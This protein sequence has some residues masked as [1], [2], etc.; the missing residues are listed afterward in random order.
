MKIATPFAAAH[1][2]TFAQ[3][4]HET[5][6]AYDR[7]LFCSDRMRIIVC[8][9]DRQWV[10]QTRKDFSSAKERPWVARDYCRTKAGI[11]RVT[12]TD[13]ALGIPGLQAFVDG[14]TDRL[15]PITRAPLPPAPPRPALN[16]S[17]GTAT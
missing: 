16:I 4:A 3:A 9:A 7:V 1:P 14:L 17:Q 8:R 13:L 12:K 5:A 10:V 2:S 15:S 11:Q 6:D